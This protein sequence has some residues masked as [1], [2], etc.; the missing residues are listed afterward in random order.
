M[1]NLTTVKKQDEDEMI[2][3]YPKMQVPRLSLVAATVLL[4]LAGQVAAQ[5]GEFRMICPPDSPAA[6]QAVSSFQ[7]V[8]YFSQVFANGVSRVIG[9]GTSA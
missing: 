2:L 9:R 3:I 5:A 1:V 6:P 7:T 8:V 4:I